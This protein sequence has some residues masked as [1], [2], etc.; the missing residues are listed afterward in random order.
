MDRKVTEPYVFQPF[1]SVSN[2]E[3]AK[4]GRLYGVGTPFHPHVKTT[5]SG[6]TR[7]EA[8]AICDILKRTRS[9][10]KTGEKPV[11]RNVHF[12]DEDRNRYGHPDDTSPAAKTGELKPDNETWK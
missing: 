2:P 12:R 8:E 9:A 3:H 10:A 1:G 11:V 5:I 7:E 4:L 6:V